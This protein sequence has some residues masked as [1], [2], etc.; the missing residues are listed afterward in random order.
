MQHLQFLR[1]RGGLCSMSFVHG[2]QDQRPHSVHSSLNSLSVHVQ[3]CL[4][5]KKMHRPGTLPQAYA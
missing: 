3:D 2:A 1:E 4:I 5:Y